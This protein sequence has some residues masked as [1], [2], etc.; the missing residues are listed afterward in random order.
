MTNWLKEAREY[1]EAGVDIP[2]NYDED[3]SSSC[4]QIAQAAALIAQVEADQERNKQLGRI[5]DALEGI[6]NA[7]S[8]APVQQ[9]Y[10]ANPDHT[11]AWNRGYE[12]GWQG[13]PEDNPHSIFSIACGGWAHGY[14]VGAEHREQR[15]G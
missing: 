12:A 3:E 10:V 1:L 14:R 8:P 7:S 9:E 11:S 15:G 4:V 2:L 13:K 6:V 5:A